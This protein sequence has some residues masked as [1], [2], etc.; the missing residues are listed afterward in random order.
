[1]K[2]L[3]CGTPWESK[4]F[5]DIADTKST[6]LETALLK[7]SYDGIIPVLCD[8]SPCTHRMKRVMSDDLDLYE[9]VEFIHDHLMDKLEL[10][11]MVVYRDVG[12]FSD[13]GFGLDALY[14]FHKK[15]SV[16]GNATYF[17]D[18][19]ATNVFLGFR[20]DM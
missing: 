11:P 13:A 18:D 7:A 15:W 16:L 12:D 20:F 2:S 5:Y 6:E 14:K 9:P 17:S 10:T 19:S 8:T 1:M 4:G 3:C